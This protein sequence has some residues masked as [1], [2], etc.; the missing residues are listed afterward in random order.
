MLNRFR[1]VHISLCLI[2]IGCFSFCLGFAA[3]YPSDTTP[4]SSKEQALAFLDKTGIPAQSKYWP[5]VA[6]AAFMRNLRRNIESPLEIY[7]GISTNFC[8]YSA[9][10]Y[11]PLHDDPLHFVRFLVQVYTQ[12]KG[13]Y[14]PVHFIPSAEILQAAGR[15]SFKGELD[16]RPADQL[17]FL[18]LADH[19]KGYLNFFDRHFDMGDENKLWAAVNFAK[20][21]RMIRLLFNYR[22]DA[23]GSD[24]FK[25]GIRDV[26]EYLSDRLATGNVAL[27]V[28]N[29]SLYKKSHATIR[30][31]VPTHFIIL[32]NVEEVGDDIAITY[33]DYGGK[34]LQILSP[35]FL[36]KIIFGVSHITKKKADAR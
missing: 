27:F 20:F 12:G 24:L 28:N 30:L 14:G 29:L 18:L 6:P 11:L 13:N 15:L 34:S 5:N 26:Y 33:W 4:L 17:W 2:A 3:G 7:E 19:F 35:S 23:V 31:G 16:V 9:L 36:K 21:N 25:P 10:S 1:Q 22:V 32:L 8:A